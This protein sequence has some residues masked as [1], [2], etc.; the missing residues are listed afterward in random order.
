VKK[1]FGMECRPSCGVCDK[2]EFCDGEHITCPPDTKFDSSVTCRPACGDCD[3]PEVCDGELNTC[4]PDVKYDSTKLCRASTG[5]CDIPEYCDGSNATCP[6]NMLH[7]I[8]TPCDDFNLCTLS[9]HCNGNGSCVG[10]PKCPDPAIKLLP[11]IQSQWHTSGFVTAFSAVI[12][13]IPSIVVHWTANTDYTMT[14]AHVFIGTNPP[15][16]D[17]TPGQMPYTFISAVPLTQF[18]IVVP[19]SSISSQ[20]TCDSSFYIML[21]LETQA[22]PNAVCGMIENEQIDDCR[23]TNG[24]SWAELGNTSTSSTEWGH[25]Y[26]Q[27]EFC[28]C[29]DPT[30]LFDPQ[31]IKKC[32][33]STPGTGKRSI[34]DTIND[35]KKSLLDSINEHIPSNHVYVISMNQNTDGFFTAILGFVTNQISSN[36]AAEIIGKSKLKGL[37]DVVISNVEQQFVPALEKTLQQIQRQEY[38]ARNLNS[39]FAV[40]LMSLILVIIGI[41]I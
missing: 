29:F 25:W 37:D 31:T 17:I 34:V 15:P 16:S 5:V 33:F 32:T 41:L 7:S 2:P 18:Q 4:P 40:T 36:T 24:T 20:S 3:K 12:N 23:N 38:L 1:P 10:N 28:C 11:T 8:I 26:S 6:P 39:G 35:A 9:D 27:F 13:G 19:I 22:G 30:S 14:Q 21:H